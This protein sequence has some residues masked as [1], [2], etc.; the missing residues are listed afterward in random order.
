MPY[1]AY[2][3]RLWPT[4]RAGLD[5]HR[6]S[7]QCVVSGERTDLADLQGLVAYLESQEDL[8]PEIT[9]DASSGSYLKCG[10]P[11]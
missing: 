11:V 6:V 1:R 3:V 4:R 2:L 10:D 8:S 9:V 5:G 7:V